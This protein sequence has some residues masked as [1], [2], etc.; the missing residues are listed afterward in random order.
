MT[1]LAM[2]ATWLRCPVCGAGLHLAD[3]SLDCPERHS[4]DVAKQGYV[5]LLGHGAPAHADTPQMVA[6]RDRFLS[7]GHYDP[8]TDAVADAVP[9]ARRVVE[10]G[11]GTGHHLARVLD[12]TPAAEGLAADISVPACRRSARAHPRMASVAA[13]TWAGLPLRDGVV[14]TV[15]CIFA[16]RNPAEFARVLTPGG[17]VVVVLP[18]PDHLREL[19]ATHGLLD[20]GEDKMERLTKSVDGHLEITSTVDV[21]FDTFLTGMEVADLIGMGPN[22]FHSRGPGSEAAHAGA[23]VRVSVTCIVLHASAT[24]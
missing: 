6:A 20:I 23:S 21:D 16:P 7:A 9:D 15:L 13:D 3:R 1:A 24:R 14:D 19:R 10:V 8:I 5:N 4:F 17:T 22:A 2:V 12:R 11:A 18:Q